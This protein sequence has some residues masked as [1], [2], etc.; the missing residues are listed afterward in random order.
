LR[1]ILLASAVLFALCGSAALGAQREHLTST[2]GHRGSRAGALH[3]LDGQLQRYE[4]KTWY[5]QRVTGKPRTQTAGRTLAAMAV[6]D[7]ERTVKR[8]AKRARAAHRV[9]QHPP[10]MQAFMCIHRFE[11]AWNDVGGPYWGGLQMSLTFQERYGGWLYRTK[12]TADHWTP[13][14]QIWTAEK[15]LKTRGFWPW[16]NTARLCGLI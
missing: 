13:L 11:G 9:A 3:Y 7:L 16:P 4:T 10:H 14:E 8:W 2:A 15:A 12:G 6:P 1:R 5:W